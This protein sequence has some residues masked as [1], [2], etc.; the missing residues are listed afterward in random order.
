MDNPMNIHGYFN[1]YFN[2]YTSIKTDILDY[3]VLHNNMYYI[4]IIYIYNDNIV[5]Y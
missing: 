4:H 5:I 3:I 2:G 1:G